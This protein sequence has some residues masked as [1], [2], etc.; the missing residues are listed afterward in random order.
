MS[1]NKSLI[2]VALCTYNGDRFLWEQLESLARQTQL[3]DELVVCDDNSSDH[4]IELVK[5]FAQTAPFKVTVFV[6]EQQLGV[7][8]NFEKALTKC[9]GDILFLCDQDDIWEPEK[10]ARMALFLE[11]N[12]SLSV[13]FSDAVLVN[14][15]AE[16]LPTT[17][18]QI[19]RLHSP[20]LE[21]WK[22]GESIKVM[23]VGNRV[24][25]CTMALRKTFLQS[26]VPFP[27]DIPEFLHDTWIAFVASV[28]EQ[29]QYIPERLVQY[30]QH[31]AQQVGTRPKNLTPLSLKQRLARPHQLKLLPY[32][33]RQRELLTLYKHLQRV[34]PQGHSNLKIVEEK[35][36]FLTVRANLPGN[37]VLRLVPVFKEWVKGNYHYF[38]DQDTSKKGIFMTA[39]GD[40][41]E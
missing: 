1:T 26:L 12:P 23:L 25:G 19:V 28:L 37:R 36:H 10:I 4:T 22:K 31:G 14:E 8:K 29:I 33:Q 7:T 2:S 6:N 5:K 41:L 21:Q 11:Q 13:V 27:N 3:P 32:Q 15:R 38:A 17:F 40:V 20:Q 9:E 18:W 39:L 34:I 16:P 30:R 24:A 35:I